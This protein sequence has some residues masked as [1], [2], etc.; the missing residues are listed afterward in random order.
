MAAGVYP[1]KW[2]LCLE[3]VTFID[4]T[5]FRFNGTD[6]GGRSMV[7]RKPVFF[8]LS[9]TERVFHALGWLLYLAGVLLLWINDAVDRNTPS[10]VSF[11]LSVFVYLPAFFYLN[12]FYLIPVL[13]QQKKWATYAGLVASI[14]VAWVF[15][16]TGI[17]CA[18]K[19]VI[20]TSFTLASELN[21]KFRAMAGGLPLILLLSFGYRFSV[22]WLDNLGHIE[23]LKAEKSTMELAFLKSQVDPH[24]LFNTLNGL[25]GLALEEGS[26][27]TADGI[28]KLGTLMRYTLH[29]A[30]AALISLDKEIDY[31][32]KYVALQEIR[33]GDRGTVKIEVDIDEER[34]QQV[35]IAPMLLISLIENAFK[36]GVAPGCRNE[37][38]IY[39]KLTADALMLEVTNAIP[40]LPPA[41][42]EGVGGVGLKN[43]QQ[44][45]VLLYPEKHRLVFGTAD[46]ANTFRATLEIELES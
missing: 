26:D 18:I 46:T 3:V 12:T 2:Q 37:I 8:A 27:K 33:M 5:F 22:D 6:E 35:R 17:T 30:A 28:A 41:G 44:R 20:G 13:L 42:K 19:A 10:V 31:I 14:T 11:L 39:L 4:V 15:L 43:L 9:R 7:G 1:I 29:D 25:Y 40:E 21:V 38:D 24:F 16:D 34:A 23:K 36:H 45:L 32:R